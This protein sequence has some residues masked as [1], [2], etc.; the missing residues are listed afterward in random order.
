MLSL[1]VQVIVQL[2]DYNLFNLKTL[3]SYFNAH[4]LILFSSHSVPAD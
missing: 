3:F 1:A 4:I 2:L